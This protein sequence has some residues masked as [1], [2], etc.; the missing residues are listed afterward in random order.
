M[1]NKGSVLQIV[2]IVFMFLTFTITTFY[3]NIVN[4]YHINSNIQYLDKQRILEIL[5]VNYY[6][7]QLI[8]DILISDDYQKD[9]VTV[10]YEVNIDTDYEVITYVECDNYK[11]S[12]S[13]YFDY[14]DYHVK[15]LE[16]GKS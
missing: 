7:E 2:L 11:Y 10:R 1:N 13:C 6:K 15:K 14:E 12:F 9:N 3:T 5:L 8:N 4:Q 16:Y